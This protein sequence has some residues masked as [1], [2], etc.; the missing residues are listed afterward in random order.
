MKGGTGVARSRIGIMGGSFN[1]IHR[2]HVQIAQHALNELDLERVIFIPNGNPPH[3]QQYLADAGHRYEMTRLALIPYQNFTASDIEINRSGV[4]YT[5]DTLKLL[6]Q[7][8][9]KNEFVYLIGEDTLFDLEHWKNPME[10]FGLCSFAVCLRSGKAIMDDP[11]IQTLRKN[12]ANLHF[13]SM[14]P[15]DISATT[16]RKQILQG[17]FDH[18]RLTPEVIEYIRINGLYGCGPLFPNAQNAYTMLKIALH[19]TRL[20]HSLS[21]AD[22][23]NH[24]AKTHGLDVTVCETAG[25]LHDCAKDIPLRQQQQIARQYRLMLSETEMSTVA[26]LHAPVGAVIANT[27]YGIQDPVILKAIT[28]HTVGRPCMSP[29][30]TAVYLADKIEPYRHEIPALDE[31]RSLADINL[32]QASY[33]MLISSKEHVLKTNKPLHPE[34]D[35]TIQWLSD[36]MY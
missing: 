1:P 36:H 15:L 26:L 23:A 25:F 16:I 2:R 6:R 28:Y 8:Y 22:T 14:N 21:V 7:E 17:V 13:L 30:E 24:L 31:I 5:V 33:Q 19:D 10:V 12:G 27:E 4:I 18:S 35:K 11:R 20:L 32:Y 9:P 3:K 34:T 29:I